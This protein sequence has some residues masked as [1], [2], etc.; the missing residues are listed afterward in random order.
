[1][2]F[3]GLFEMAQVPYKYVACY[4]FLISKLMCEML[5]KAAA[6]DVRYEVETWNYKK[7]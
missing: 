6:S 1:M 7:N 2:R 5:T 3:V 4:I